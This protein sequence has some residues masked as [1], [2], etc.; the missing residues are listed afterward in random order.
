MEKHDV[1]KYA[2]QTAD[3]SP[4]KWAC[5]E[6]LAPCK[7]NEKQPRL[8]EPTLET[9]MRYSQASYRWYCWFDA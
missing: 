9:T 4:K 3:S 8:A 6:L 1:K 2:Q 7:R 5:G